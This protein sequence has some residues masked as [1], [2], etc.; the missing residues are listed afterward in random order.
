MRQCAFLHRE[1]RAALRSAAW[2]LPLR[3]LCVIITTCSMPFLLSYIY[4]PFF[5]LSFCALGYVIQGLGGF[6]FG[7]GCQALSKWSGPGQIEV[8]QRSEGVSGWQGAVAQSAVAQ[9][10]GVCD[11]AMAEVQA[12]HRSVYCRAH[13]SRKRIGLF[14]STTSE[15]HIL[16]YSFPLMFY[17]TNGI[18]RRSVQYYHSL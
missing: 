17:C 7:R 8:L 12:A 13:Y 16:Y 5:L 10:R 18:A 11:S 2:L 6:F 1:C 15:N 3:C 14:H 4:I 9:W